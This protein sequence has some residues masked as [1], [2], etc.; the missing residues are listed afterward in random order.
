MFEPMLAHKL[1]AKKKH[2][3]FPGYVQPKLDGMRGCWDRHSLWS[4]SQH[5]IISVPS[6]QATLQKYFPDWELDGELYTH[7]ADFED[8]MSTAR[9]TVN[10]EED[11]RLQY[12]IYDAPRDTYFTE[13]WNLFR[14]QYNTMKAAP[15][16]R[17]ELSRIIL[18]PTHV[19]TNMKDIET[20]LI[21]YKNAGY[22][23]IVYRNS[24][25]TYEVGKRSNGLLKM[26]VLEGEDLEMEVRV[27]N[28]I[29]GMGKHWGRLGAVVCEMPDGKTFKVGTGFDDAER[30][31]YWKNNGEAIIGKMITVHYESITRKGVLRFPAFKRVRP[32]E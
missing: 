20:Y 17:H 9:R 16:A 25:Y 6:L 2:I 18:V 30:E 19:V 21:S 7:D 28:I 27:T 32:E 10:I 31:K 14:H 8:I 11:P 23:G 1:T 13:R 15:D 29:P 24:Q 5:Q 12:W 3:T 26:R 4:R 22:E